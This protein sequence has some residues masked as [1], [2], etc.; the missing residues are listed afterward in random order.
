MFAAI[1]AARPKLV[2]PHILRG[3]RIMFAYK[4]S[5]NV[6]G[7]L[8]GISTVVQV[9]HTLLRHD[10]EE[11]NNGSLR[12]WLRGGLW[13]HVNCSGTYEEDIGEQCSLDTMQAEVEEDLEAKYYAAPI[14]TSTALLLVPKTEKEN[15][16][17]RKP[18]TYGSRI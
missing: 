2:K 6:L 4:V 16:G 11:F 13:P 15:Q 18:E 10:L 1:D 17:L 5:N 7:E 3:T 8:K 12:A 14:S 9:G